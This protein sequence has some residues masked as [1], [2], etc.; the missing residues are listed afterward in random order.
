MYLAE[1]FV[2]TLTL[3]YYNCSC[4]FVIDISTRVILLK[5]LTPKFYI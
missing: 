1:P 2:Y 4:V 3:V 5:S